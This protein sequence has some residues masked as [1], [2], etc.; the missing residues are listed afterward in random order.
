MAAAGTLGAASCLPPPP[1]GT[2]FSF[3]P[4][5]ISVSDTFMMSPKTLAAASEPVVAVFGASLPLTAAGWSPLFAHAVA[6]PRATASP[7]GDSGLAGDGGDCGAT[8]AMDV[9]GDGGGAAWPGAACMRATSTRTPANHSPRPNG[10]TV[11][12]RGGV[13]G[14]DDEVDTGVGDSGIVSLQP[15]AWAPP[16]P[17]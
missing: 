3:A 9:A 15:S 12:A 11:F 1:P 5:S 4:S 17:R 8:N 16:T 14:A 13:D 10:R 7:S 6:A 2:F